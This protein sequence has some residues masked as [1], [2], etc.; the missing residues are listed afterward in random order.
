MI[1]NKRTE[2]YWLILKRVEKEKLSGIFLNG[3]HVARL[4]SPKALKKH[5]KTI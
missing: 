5:T 1:K 2:V 4:I 3:V